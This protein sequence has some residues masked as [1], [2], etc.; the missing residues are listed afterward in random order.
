MIIQCEECQSRF[1]V[2]DMVIGAKGRTVRCGKCAHT[3]FQEPSP[4]QAGRDDLPGIDT[5]IDEINTRAKPIPKG[6][7]VPKIKRKPMPMLHKVSLAVMSLIT[8]ALLLLVAK[9]GVYG[10][11]SS[12]GLVLADV[13][14][15]RVSDKDKHISYQING[16]I[17]NTTARMM[18]VPVLRIT[19]VDK[20]GTSLQYWDFPFPS[21]IPSLEAGKDVPFATG[22]LAIR[23]DKGTR[24]VAELGSSLE[25]ALRRK[26][27]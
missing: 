16:K 15:L 7:N 17:A 3:W 5:L 10:V 18:K 1:L 21:D 23:F 22:D 26:P 4:E 2:P 11:P 12:K 9:P 27:Q 24:F 19:L 25:L 13:G 6:S 8:T 14:I 20:D